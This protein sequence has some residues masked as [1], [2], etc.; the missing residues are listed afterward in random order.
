M[1]GIVGYNDEANYGAP[2][3]R[4]SYISAQWILG[5]LPKEFEQTDTAIAILHNKQVGEIY[6]RHR[7][8]FKE[9]LRDLTRLQVDLT[10]ARKA[11]EVLTITVKEKNAKIRRMYAE[12]EDLRSGGKCKCGGCSNSFHQCENK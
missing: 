4:L 1:M 5:N 12:L 11:V 10:E 6:S 2:E 8:Y 3:V 9:A 7:D